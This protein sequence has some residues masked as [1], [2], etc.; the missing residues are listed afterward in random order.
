MK[1]LTKSMMLSII[2]TISSFSLFAQAKTNSLGIGFNINQIQNDYGIGIDIISPYF[3]NSK[4]AIRVGGSLKWLEYIDDEETSWTPYQNIQVGHR[5]RQIIIEDK[6]YCYGEGGVLL[7]FPNKE[8][9][10][11]SINFGGY[12]LFGFEFKPT[13]KFGYYLEL[14]GVGSGARA[15]KVINKPIYSNGFI[16]AVGLRWII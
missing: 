13:N 14:G 12:G 2:L 7:L 11:E 15:D 10:S 9:S 16:T 8:F 5:V 4:L 3:A 6:L 1:K